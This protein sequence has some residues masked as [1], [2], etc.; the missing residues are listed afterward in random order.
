MIIAVITVYLL[1]VITVGILGHR[2]FRGTGDDYFVASRTIGPFVLLMTLLGT[3]MTAFTILGASSQ[4]FQSGI[5]VF[6]LMASSSAIVIPILFYYC[7]TRCWWLGKRFGYVTQVQLVRDRYGS[8]ALGTLLFLVVVLLMLPYILIGVKGGGDTMTAL[9]GGEWPTWVGSLLVCG[10]TFIYVTYGG[11][12]ST[13]WAN[14]FQT[15]VFVIVG[16]VAWYVVMNRYGGMGQ[17]M[18]QLRESRPEL[19]AVGSGR[20]MTLQ[21]LSFMLVPL[22]TAAFP[23]I[24]SHWLSANHGKSLRVA[25]VFYPICIAAIWIPSVTLGVVGN[26][27]FSPESLQGPVIVALILDNAS[28]ILAGCLAAGVFAAIMSSL[29]SQ[30][31]ALGAMFTEDIV[32]YYGFG[33]K[34]SDRQQVLFGRGFVV[35]ILALAFVSALVTDRSIFALGTWSL[36]G[37]AG[38]LPLFVATLYWP[39]STKAGAACGLV[40]AAGLWLYFYWDS[41]GTSGAY[42]VAGTGLMPVAVILPASAIVL[43]VVSYLS[44]PP[45]DAARFFP[46]QSKTNQR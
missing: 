27:D 42:S 38:L 46:N 4:A 44:T 1:L 34:L 13:A 32:R 22:C 11:M 29:D 20:F 16:G 43:V 2:L 40:T 35:A 15:A 18:T 33:G 28:G 14:T 23:H 6:L 24:Y 21:M 39:R 8:G 9:T 17:A 31:L 37:F 45:A 3:N 26:L 25:V 10:V 19:I 7:G 36:T 41:L 12:R 5:S 30:T